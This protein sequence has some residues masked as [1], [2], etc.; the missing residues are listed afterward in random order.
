M[1]GANLRRWLRLPDCPEV[2]QDFKAIF[3]KAFIPSRSVDVGGIGSDKL[4]KDTR[5]AAYFTHE[6]RFGSVTY[7]RASSH[8][9]NSVVLYFP[10]G[11]TTEPAAGE[12]QRISILHGKPTFYVRQYI[13]LSP[14]A[15]DPFL[16]YPYI[17]ATTYQ[18]AFSPTPDVIPLS[19]ILSHGARYTFSFD[20][21]VIVNLCRV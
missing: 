1:R 16:T 15:H 5:D 13:P 2:I 17:G 9:G 12:I 18:A 3:D 7:S 21:V 10:N 11:S 14:E 4:R 19:S 20:R 6:S 8:R